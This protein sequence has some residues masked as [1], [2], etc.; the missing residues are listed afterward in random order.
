MRSFIV[1]FLKNVKEKLVKSKTFFY[2][3]FKKKEKLLCAPLDLF[4]HL[5]FSY[6]F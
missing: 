2:Y 6:Y 4:L 5:L 1:D 3:S